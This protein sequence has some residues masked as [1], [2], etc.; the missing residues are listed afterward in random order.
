MLFPSIN[1]FNSMLHLMVVIL[2]NYHIKSQTYFHGKLDN[3]VIACIKLDPLNDFLW[4]EIYRRI[5]IKLLIWKRTAFHQD[6]NRAY[7]SQSLLST[8]AHEISLSQFIAYSDRS[9]LVQTIACT[10][11]MNYT[12]IHLTHFTLYWL[13]RCGLMISVTLVNSSGHFY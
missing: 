7:Q 3:V 11:T 9:W 10:V 8:G 4:L 5:G 6:M 1:E 2:Q 12:F 13:T